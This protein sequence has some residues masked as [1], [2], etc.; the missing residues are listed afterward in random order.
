M[1]IH[2]LATSVEGTRAAPSAAKP[3]AA[4]SGLP[5][6]LMIPTRPDDRATRTGSWPATSKSPVTSDSQCACASESRPAP[7]RPRPLTP[8]DGVVVIGGAARWWW[9]TWESGWRRNS[10]ARPRRRLR[11][12]QIQE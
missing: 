12:M 4:Q 10:A 5:V 9:P 7:Q 8:P 2:V 11:R 6:V 3:I 1:A